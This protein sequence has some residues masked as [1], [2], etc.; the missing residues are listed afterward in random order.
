MINDIKIRKTCEYI[1]T[2]ICNECKRENTVGT[3][4]ILRKLRR[5]TARCSGCSLREHNIN[6]DHNK[7]KIVNMN[8]NSNTNTNTNTKEEIHQQSITEFENYD[9]LYQQSY[10]SSHLTEEDYQRIRKNII[11]FGNGTYTDVENYEFW[12]VYKVN[13]QM[14]FSSVLYDKKYSCI[15][16]ANQ[17]I[18]K[19][20]NCEKH[21]RCKSIESFKNDYKILCSDCKFC[22]RTFKIRPTKNIANQTIL[23]QSKLEWKFIEWCNH[24]QYIVV[25]GPMIDYTF[26]GK[27]R[28]Y[29]VDFQIG[30][31]LIEIKDYHV[32]HKNQ[33]E[34]GVWN[35]KLKAV[36][37]YI[38]E[39]G[40]RKY[41]F[42]TPQN[43]NQQIKEMN[44]SF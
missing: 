1:V 42:V 40:L 27:A 19:C 2:Y 16:K 44:H 7:E 20:D 15:F 34:S 21:W 9:E 4:Q 43:W 6:P 33:V 29:R 17:P 11:S 31:L 23:Y 30:D 37:K 36:N 5:E 12:S 28:K 3:T 39:K 22:N 38:E 41:I 26:H 14:R 32:W 35:S 10:F 24:H 25:N 18:M 13:N 8:T